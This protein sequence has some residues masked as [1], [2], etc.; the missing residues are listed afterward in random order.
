MVLENF[1]IDVDVLWDRAG[2]EL[3]EKPDARAGRKMRVRVTNKGLVEDLTGYALN[4][5]WRSTIDETKFGLDAFTAVDITKGIFEL[6]YTSGMLTNIGTLVGTLQLV[7]PAGTPTES[8]NFMITV[9]RSGVDMEAIQSETSFTALETALVEVTGWNARID[10]VEQDFIDRANNLDATYP[11]RLVSVE[12]QLEQ[13]ATT[14]ALQAVA[15]GSPKGTYAT[16]AALQTA[17]PTGNGNIYVVT[18]N[19]NWYYWSGSAWTA[20]GVYQSTGINDKSITPYHTQFLSVGTNIF[21]KNNVVTGYYVSNVDGTLAVN[22]SYS[23]SELIPILPNT[24]YT[25]TNAQVIA[26]YDA[27]KTFISGV[28]AGGAT[29]VTTPAN[30]AYIR[31]S[32]ANTILGSYQLQK[33]DVSTSYESF[34]LLTNPSLPVKIKATDIP[35]EEL[36]GTN[37]KNG[38]LTP[39]KTSMFVSNQNLFNIAT[40]TAGKAVGYTNGQLADNASYGASDYIEVKP[41]TQYIKSGTYQLA[42]YDKDKVYISG[43]NNAHVNPFT[44]P[45]NT[46]F[47]RLTILTTDPTAYPYYMMVEGATLPTKFRACLNKNVDYDAILNPLYFLDSRFSKWRGKSWY[48]IGDSMSFADVYTKEVFKRCDMATYAN[49]GNAGSSFVTWHT[50][51]WVNTTTVQAS[52]LVTVFLGTNDYSGNQT[53]GTINDDK[54]Q[55][56]VYGSI[57]WMI[58]TILVAKPSVRLAFFTPLQ[59]GAFSTGP[60]FPA[61]NGIGVTL[62]QIVQAIK[63]VCGLYA[64]P[65]CDLFNISGLN[66]Y[67]LTYYTADNLHPTTAFYQKIGAMMAN[68]L[69]TL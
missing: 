62:Q 5:G 38:T 6:P 26:Y 21:N 39:N 9:K 43:L 14:T 65:V 18:A 44:T 29:T 57:K 61:P 68:F 37:I 31:V 42:F 24:N 51:N 20:G 54:T 47:V 34:Y 12:Q 59:R 16:L 45:P 17:F 11:T 23:T 2:K 1:L 48:V 10:D 33:G 7:P 60:V 55:N 50:N 15:S 30:A 32:I 53:L 40:M 13:K 56:T 64:I 25:R 19:G 28:A 27:G 58:D 3:Y 63:D 35:L 66:T 8:N 67:N 49:D 22:A 69:E 4:L 41:N 36:T 46:Y 52:D